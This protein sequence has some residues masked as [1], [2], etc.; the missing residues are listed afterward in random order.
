MGHH[1][2]NKGSI[3]IIKTS[4]TNLDGFVCVCDERDEQTEHHVDEKR[5]EGVEV[6][7]AEQPHHVALRSHL[8]KGREHVVPVDQREQ[9]VRH[10][11]QGSELK[12]K[13]IKG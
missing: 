11:V 7:A 12:Q 3:I 1:C 2:I 4:K 6:E 9:A 5:D 10:L 13:L 8:L